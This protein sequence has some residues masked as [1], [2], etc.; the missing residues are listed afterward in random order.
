MDGIGTVTAPRGSTPGELR[1]ERLLP[2]DL[3]RVWHYVTDAE[4]RGRWLASGPMEPRLG[5]AVHLTWHNLDLSPHKVPAPEAHKDHEN[6]GSMRGRI[7]R[8]EPPHAVGFTW[9]EGPDASEVLIEL[10]AHGESGGVRLVLT[11][12]RV[13]ERPRLLSFSSGWHA[14]LDVL[15]EVLAGRVPGPF[16]ASIAALEEVYAARL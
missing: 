5:G 12:R 10:S 9:G 13:F 6:C 7:I 15:A 1:F 8:W 14:H 11:H 4:A 2:G 3:A 16:W